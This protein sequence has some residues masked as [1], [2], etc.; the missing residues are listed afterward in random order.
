MN[1]RDIDQFYINGQ[2]VQAKDRKVIEI[3]NPA[4]GNITGTLSLG[5]EADIDQAVLAA[6]K[7][8]ES[9]SRWSRQARIDLIASIIKKMKRGNDELAHAI[10]LE[11]G[12]PAS[13][14]KWTQARAAVAHFREVKRV[15]QD[16]KF[17]DCIDNTRLR[18]E[19]IGV[20][21]LITPWNWPINQITAKVAA[22]L[23]AGCTMVLKPSE[24][25]PLSADVFTKILDEAGV[26]AGV[27]NLVHGTGDAIGSYLASHPNVDMISFTGSTR[28]G[29]AVSIA[30][31][32]TIKRVALE[33]GGKSAC[34]LLPDADLEDVMP[35][36][37]S[38][39]MLNSGQS[40][41]A[42]AR[43]LVPMQ[44]L[45]HAIEQGEKALQK[46]SIGMPS[47]NCDLGPIANEKQYLRVKKL[48]NSAAAQGAK[49]IPSAQTLPTHLS[50]GFFI[51]PTI[52]A[53]VTSTMEI[54]R[55]EIFGP[56]VTITAYDS[57]DEAIELAN[58]TNYGLS[59][60]VW[61][62]DKELVYHVASR[63]RTGMVH[64]NGAP[65]DIAAPFG[66][67]KASGNGREYGIFG[68][69]EYLEVKSIYGTSLETFFSDKQKNS[70]AM[71]LERNEKIQLV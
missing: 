16:F 2:W 39:V 36:A 20:C 46:I 43:I 61:G 60:A 9:Y 57:I 40:C 31:A 27:F 1:N 8:F 44:T 69:K 18:Y 24:L 50:A 58:D 34:I 11:I 26:P 54:F 64:L 56:V 6:C 65:L 32:P 45:N 35:K 3:T 71:T 47:D 23:A 30:A 29:E 33:L 13:F 62:Q 42:A 7:A 14:A 55:E 37:I 51:Q 68:L 66:G 70:P 10:S 19:P 59:G 15:I 63:L 17:E 21:G 48:I 67:Y 25:A 52:I 5:D 53:N 38:N 49:I 41:N 12:A 28:A 4:T 22:A